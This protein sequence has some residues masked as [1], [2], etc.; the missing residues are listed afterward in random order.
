MRSA[1]GREVGIERLLPAHRSEEW[2]AHRDDNDTFGGGMAKYSFF[3]FSNCTDPNREQEFNRWY[4]HIHLVDLSAAKGFVSARRYV[5]AEP[6]ARA[7]YLAVYD[8]D[9]DDIDASIKSLYELAAQTW[10]KRRHIDCI[11]PAPAVASPV[12]AFREID[13]RSLEP[14]KPHEHANYPAEMP[15]AVRRG[16]AAQ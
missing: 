16:F 2:V 9:T 1:G 3:V 12:M 4:T 10:P 11:A 7:K 14:L 15:E 5:S 13:P 6:A 8:F